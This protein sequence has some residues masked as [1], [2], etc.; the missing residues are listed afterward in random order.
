MRNH[1]GT[2]PLIQG[3]SARIYNM[4]FGGSNVP[5]QKLLTERGEI[6]AII[7]ELCYQPK[8]FLML[9]PRL[10][11]LFLLFSST[12]HASD[13]VNYQRLGWISRSAAEKLP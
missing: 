4:V 13:A 12:A 9:S 11:C 1:I 3:L 7:T 5:L 6:F 10:L 2:C 8:F